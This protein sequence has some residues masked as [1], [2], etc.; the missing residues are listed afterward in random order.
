MMPRPHR[1]L[2]LVLLFVIACTSPAPTVATVAPTVPTATHGPIV[3][4]PGPTTKQVRLQTFDVP[5]GSGPHD[6]APAFDPATETFASFPFP[7]P[8]ANVRQLNGRPGEVWGAMSGQDKLVVAHLDPATSSWASVPAA[9]RHRGGSILC[10]LE[11]TPL[12]LTL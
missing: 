6:V 5:K 9:G 8:N 4:S 12:K 1:P 11:V 2:A 7:L 10:G 3:A